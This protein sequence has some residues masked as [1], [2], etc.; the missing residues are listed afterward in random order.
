MK[1]FLMRL[2]VYMVIMSFFFNIDHL[3][4][5]GGFACGA[6]LALI[7][8]RERFRSRAETLFWQVLSFA[9]VLLVLYAFYQVAAQGKL[10]GGI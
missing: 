5:I 2:I 9:S 7:L 6:L 4:H 10:S 8:P 1:S 3:A